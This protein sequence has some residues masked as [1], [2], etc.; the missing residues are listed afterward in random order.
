[1]RLL[2]LIG[3]LTLSMVACKDDK[4]EEVVVDY[5]ERDNQLIVDYLTHN[6]IT[7]AQKDE[8]SGL[9]YRIKNEGEGAVVAAKD[10]V[11]VQYLGYVVSRNKETEIPELNAKPFDFTPIAE[12]GRRMK[13]SSLIAG[14]KIGIP[15]IKKG[16]SIYLYIPSHLGYGS[17]YQSGIPTNSVLYFDIDLEDV[18]AVP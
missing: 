9:Y 13:L 15:K 12:P 2:I 4:D 5:R 16:G 17:T 1:M 18:V 6:N 7:D 3:L 14:W 11:V 10:T 8:E